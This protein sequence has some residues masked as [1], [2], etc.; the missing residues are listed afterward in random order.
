M[1]NRPAYLTETH[2][3]A[4]L[5]STQLDMFPAVP[6]RL[7]SLDSAPVLF[8]ALTGADYAPAGFLLR[9]PREETA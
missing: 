7:V 2:G 8:P 4:S 6:P 9:Q 1:A 3:R 5:D